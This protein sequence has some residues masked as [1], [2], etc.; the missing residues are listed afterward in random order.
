MRG[1]KGFARDRKNLKSAHRFQK[2]FHHKNVDPE[3]VENKCEFFSGLSKNQAKQETR[4]NELRLK[5]QLRQELKQFYRLERQQAVKSR[6]ERKL[7]ANTVIIQT[8]VTP[9]VIPLVIPSVNPS[10]IPSVNPP[11]IPSVNPSVIPS[12]NPSVN[13]PVNPPVIPSDQRAV[14][15]TSEDWTMVEPEQQIQPQS[16]FDFFKLFRI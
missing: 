15:E 11:V 4:Q 6:K 1:K 9:S 10:V 3:E 2:S 16:K 8:P 13:P 12:V 5:K 14:V 7:M